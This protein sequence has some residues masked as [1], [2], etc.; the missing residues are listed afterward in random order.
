MKMALWS[1]TL[2]KWLLDLGKRNILSYPAMVGFSVLKGAARLLAS[3]P[4]SHRPP[5]PETD[6]AGA[7]P[8]LYRVG[9]NLA[10]YQARGGTAGLIFS[11][12]SLP[13]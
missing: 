1:Q 11:W 8:W 2:S 9:R 13:K 6:T 12:S 4:F 3:P 5:H 7:V 10:L